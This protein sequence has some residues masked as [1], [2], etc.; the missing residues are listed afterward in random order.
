MT[1]HPSSLTIGMTAHHEAGHVTVAIVLRRP[2]EAIEVSAD[3]SGEF[4]PEDQL[5]QMNCETYLQVGT[6]ERAEA[7]ARVLVYMGGIEAQRRYLVD[8]GCDDLQLERRMQTCSYDL[9]AAREI[10]TGMT[11]TPAEADAYLDWLQLR[12]AELWS[13]PSFWNDVEIVA[14]ALQEHGRLT[15]R[16]ALVLVTTS[17]QRKSPAPPNAGMYCANCR[18]VNC[19]ERVGAS[20]AGD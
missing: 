12:A 20:H 4:F 14:A 18:K 15:E 16:N 5:L 2:F 19:P 1:N 17:T 8:V 13:L 11:A 9:D 3:G 6:K 7:E 10:A